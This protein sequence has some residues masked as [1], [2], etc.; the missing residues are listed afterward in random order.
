M[1]LGIAIVLIVLW[2]LLR[3]FFKVTKSIVHIALL[4]GVIALAIHFVRAR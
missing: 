3:V 4:A 2:L 1:T